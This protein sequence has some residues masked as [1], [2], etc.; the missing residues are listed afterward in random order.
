[1]QE[2]HSE[3]F[4]REAAECRQKAE[5]ADQSD[6]QAWLRLAEGWDDLAR[7]DD[8]DQEWRRI[9]TLNLHDAHPVTL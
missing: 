6:K 4:R 8:L 5:Q 1:M 2:V 7:G 9:Q 3:K